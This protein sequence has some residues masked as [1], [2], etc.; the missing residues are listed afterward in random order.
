MNPFLK[1]AEEIFATARGAGAEDCELAI[2]I[3]A[4]GSI[5]ILEPAGWELESLRIHHGAHAAYRVQ[6]LAGQVRLEARTS[7][8]ACVLEGIRPQP[9]LDGVLS[10]FPRYLTA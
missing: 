4:D 1:H 5:R 10:D 7:S 9:T 8:Q 2:L 6:R 3:A